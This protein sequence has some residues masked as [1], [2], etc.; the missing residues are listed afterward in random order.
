MRPPPR[1][2]PL[3][4]MS[5]SAVPPATPLFSPARVAGL[6]EGSLHAS[7]RSYCSRASTQP[8]LQVN[9]RFQYTPA[10]TATWVVHVRW[11]RALGLHTVACLPCP[12]S[13]ATA[14]T[15]NSPAMRA[16]VTVIHLQPRASSGHEALRGRRQHNDTPAPGGSIQ[17]HSPISSHSRNTAAAAAVCFSTRSRPTPLRHGRVRPLRLARPGRAWHRR[18]R[19]AIFPPTRLHHRRCRG[20]SPSHRRVGRRRRVADEAQGEPQAGPRVRARAEHL[21]APHVGV[22]AVLVV[23]KHRHLRACDGAGHSPRSSGWWRR[24]G[25]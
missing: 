17:S 5:P 16:S 2:R 14:G 23:G 1:V 11:P 4:E 18:T 20:P 10:T 9:W 3:R 8:A 6:T 24:N 7:G 13:G 22:A 21:Y 15:R 25:G 19:R 12:A